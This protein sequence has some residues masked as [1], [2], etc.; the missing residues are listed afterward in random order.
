MTSILPGIQASQV[1]AA[2]T[3]VFFLCL[4]YL[5]GGLAGRYM[6]KNMDGWRRAQFA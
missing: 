5:L 1:A 3:C 4:F 2:F 6:E